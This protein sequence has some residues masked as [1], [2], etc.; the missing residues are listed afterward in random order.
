MKSLVAFFEIPA[1][2]FG[3]AVMFYETVLS[4]KLSVYETGE[5]KMACFP[6]EDGLC[7]GSV[8]FAAGFKPSAGEGVLVSLRCEDIGATLFPY[9]S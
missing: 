5:E 7:P 2:D 6:E 9:R 8:S 1:A 4:V 3:R